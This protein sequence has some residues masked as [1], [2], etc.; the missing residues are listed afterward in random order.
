VDLDGL[1]ASRRRHLRAEGK[2]ARTIKLYD[3][4]ARYLAE[5][6]GDRN[7]SQDTVA[8]RRGDTDRDLMAGLKPPIVPETPV[9]VPT[10][11]DL[12]V[13]WVTGKRSRCRVVVLS[14]KTV[15][16][17]DR[18]SKVRAQQRHAIEPSLWLFQRGPLS[19]DGADERLRDIA[20]QAGV[21]GVHA[22]RFR[23][24]WG[25]RLVRRQR[26]R[27]GHQAARRLADRYHARPLRRVDGRR[28]SPESGRPDATRR[29]L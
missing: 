6:A 23:H 1:R 21:E 16:A 20:A 4:A 26:Q 14:L 13:A 12:A 8:A 5:W 29:S 24:S 9:P 25:P 2:A 15:R 17:L 28:T 10:D 19:K 22:H 27:T 11:E 18:H 7:L 3:D